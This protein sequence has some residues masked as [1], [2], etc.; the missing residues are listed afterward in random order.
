MSEEI[1][2]NINWDKW[3]SGKYVKIVAGIP[4][5]LTLTS[6][7]ETTK[8]I[9]QKDNSIKEV[10][11][12]V[13]GVSREDGKDVQ[14]EYSVSSKKLVNM[15]KPIIIRTGFPLTVKITSYGSGF[16]TNY[17]VEEIRA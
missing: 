9:K 8:P 3:E 2:G 17:N 4:K 13:F 10:A 1:S 14:M 15:L 7:K 16:E 6:A 12:I 5:V 11:C